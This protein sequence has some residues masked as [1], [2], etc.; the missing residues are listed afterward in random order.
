MTAVRAALS[1]L[2]VRRLP[3]H[4][5][6][7][8]RTFRSLR[9]RNFR[10]YVSGQAVSLTGT[11]MQRLGQEWLVLHLT[12]SGAWLGVVAALQ[13]L[14][15]LTIGPWGGLIADRVDK[16]RMLLV[17]QSTAGVL[18]AILGVAT[19]TGVVQLWMVLVLALAL[20]L[21]TALDNPTRQAL[22]R[23]DGGPGRRRQRG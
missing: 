3:L 1:G 2:D 17:T 10:L 23:R 20:G 11:W 7:P 18:A 16:R 9:G 5:P 15:L 8:R 19:L 6:D 22:R 13:F 4:L 12:G 21:V 14:P